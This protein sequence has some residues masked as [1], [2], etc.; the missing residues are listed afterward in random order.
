MVARRDTS[1]IRHF[2]D[3]VV[4]LVVAIRDRP[5]DPRLEPYREHTALATPKHHAVERR[6]HAHAIG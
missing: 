6:V 1:F 4:A 3:P 5:E 2:A